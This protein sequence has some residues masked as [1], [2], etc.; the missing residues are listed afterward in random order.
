M[1]QYDFGIIDPY[2]MVGVEL[3]DALN[4]WRDAI[5][6]MQRGSSRPA[7]VV[8]GQL[9]INDSAGPTNWQLMWY[10]S[11]TA[12]DVPL[13]SLNTT[14]GAVTI[15][16]AQGGTFNAAVLLA[17]AAA[18]PSV[19]WNASGNPIDVKNW[20]MTVNGTGALVLSCFNDAGVLQNSITFNRD[21]TISAPYREQVAVGGE[22]QLGIQ[23]PANCKRVELEWNVVASTGDPTLQLQTMQGGTPFTG[24]HAGQL[25]VATGATNAVGAVIGGTPGWQLS[26]LMNNWG[27]ARFP[28][29]PA[30]AQQFGVAAYAGISSTGA[31]FAYNGSLFG[32]ASIAT[33]TGFR[34]TWSTAAT[35]TANNFLRAF[36]VA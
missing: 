1:S 12:G 2:V 20:R 18:S 33:T 23:I 5:Y 6:S 11:P 21:G 32:G 9:W 10:V 3:A 30:G 26:N 27:S 24:T 17:Q 31:W 7:F 35:F 25:M 36:V 15:S 16:A 28:P 8:P 34:L 19:Q 13:F 14:T 22:T 4:Q 29:R